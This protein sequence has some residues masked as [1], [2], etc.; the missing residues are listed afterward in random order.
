MESSDEGG[1]RW[2]VVMREG[3][4]VMKGR[5]GALELSDEKPNIND[6]H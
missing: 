6:S 2:R 3:R 5:E 4:A 1:G